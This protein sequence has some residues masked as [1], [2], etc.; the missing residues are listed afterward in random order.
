MPTEGDAARGG[1]FAGQTALVTGGSRGI[2]KAIALH[3][4]RHGA[5]V[6]INYRTDASAAAAVVDEV[7]ALGGRAVSVQAD[8]TDPQQATQMIDRV[9][10]GLGVPGIV[11]NNVG[12]FFLK[13]VGSMTHDEWRYVLD[14]NLSS[15]YYVCRAVLGS[16]RRQGGGRIINLGLSPMYT[17]RGAAN[18]AAYALAKA[19]VG[20]LTRSLAVEEARH[21]ITVNCVAPGL[22]DNGYLPVEQEVWMRERVPM[23]RLGRP[24]EVAEVVGFLASSKASYVSGAIVAVGGAWDWEDRPTDHDRGVWDLFVGAAGAEHPDAG[25]NTQG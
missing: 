24:E 11:V 1:E 8:L 13:P 15:V 12:D 22:I 20:V 17:V 7:R 5:D 25:S 2:G 16:M 3:F 10:G 23:G 9:V 14:S 4:A 6:A 21:G 18:I 19:G